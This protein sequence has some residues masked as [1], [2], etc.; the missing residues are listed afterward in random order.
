M[1]VITLHFNYDH[2]LK[3][4]TKEKKNSKIIFNKTSIKRKCG[5]LSARNFQIAHKLVKPDLYE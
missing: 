3:K 5:I 4:R 1:I 2:M